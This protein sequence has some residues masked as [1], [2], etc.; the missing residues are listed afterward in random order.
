MV[1]ELLSARGTHSSAGHS[2]WCQ[3]TNFL[4]ANLKFPPIST[5]GFAF[6]FSTF[7]GARHALNTDGVLLHSIACNDIWL[8]DTDKES[9]AINLLGMSWTQWTS[10]ECQSISGIEKVTLSLLFYFTFYGFFYRI[11]FQQTFNDLWVGPSFILHEDTR[12][13]RTRWR[14]LVV[15]WPI[16]PLLLKFIA[17]YD[18]HH[19]KHPTSLFHTICECAADFGRALIAIYTSRSHSGGLYMVVVVVVPAEEITPN[20]QHTTI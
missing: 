10:R 6:V 18:R 16:P 12:M 3:M 13:E 1:A 4:F 11:W 15:R 17:Y 2:C 20:T 9:T 19:W 8:S 14:M 7:H 5:K